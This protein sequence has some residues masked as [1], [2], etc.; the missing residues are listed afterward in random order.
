MLKVNI[1]K[2]SQ[3]QIFV[4][5]SVFSGI[6]K[7][8]GNCHFQC[9]LKIIGQAKKR[10]SV[11]VYLILR[12]PY[13][14]YFC[15]ITIIKWSRIS[16]NSIRKCFFLEIYFLKINFPLN[17]LLQLFKHNAKV[18]DLSKMVSKVIFLDLITFLIHINARQQKLWI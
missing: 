5:G 10:V 14:L 6:P 3:K 15:H 12:P 7:F 11:H 9:K 17:F 13:N 18:K 16:Q 2:W 8:L 1:V 4:A